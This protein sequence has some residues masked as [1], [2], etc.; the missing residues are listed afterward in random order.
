MGRVDFIPCTKVRNE[1]KIDK[2][3]TLQDVWRQKNSKTTETLCKQNPQEKINKTRQFF[4]I[5]L[6]TM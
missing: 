1:F 4:P 2:A 6:N 5:F 3:T